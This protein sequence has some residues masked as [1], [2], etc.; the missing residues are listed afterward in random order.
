M[1]ASKK[2]SKGQDAGQ[3]EVQAKFDEA[4]ELGFFGA[5]ADPT[6]NENYT[7]EGVT[8]GA[9][10]PE[11]DLDLAAEAGSTRLRGSS[12]YAAERAERSAAR[13][14]QRGSSA[15]EGGSPASSSGGGSESG[16]A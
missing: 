10:T 16:G 9:P 5:K 1:P 12:Q 8:S 11:T 13:G 2:S 15:A 14:S 3:A 6:P 4:E 7:V